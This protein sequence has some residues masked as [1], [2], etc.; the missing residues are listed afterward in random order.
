[1]SV[2]PYILVVVCLAVLFLLLVGLP[3]WT[4]IPAGLVM[5]ALMEVFV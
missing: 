3:W 4:G 1:M 2:I 5:C